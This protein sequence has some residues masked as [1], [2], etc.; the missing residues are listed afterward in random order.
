MPGMR[1]MDFRFE[2]LRVSVVLIMWVL[3]FC[4]CLTD[5]FS[6]QVEGTVVADP[7]DAIRVGI[8]TIGEVMMIRG[9]PDRVIEIEGR[10]ILIYERALYQQ[11][12]LSLGIP[13]SDIQGPSAELSSYGGLARYDT[14][15]LF[16]TPSGIL[17]DMVYEKDSVVPFFKILF[18]TEP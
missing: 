1:R 18:K 2:R 14:L 7:G 10:N 5:Q 6:R 8:S 3:T 16:F 12:R 17:E 15:T 13:F 11:S 9:A 4:G